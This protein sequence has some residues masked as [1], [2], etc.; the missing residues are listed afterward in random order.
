[1]AASST[2]GIANPNPGLFEE[3]ETAEAQMGFIGYPENIIGSYSES[4]KAG[5]FSLPINSLVHHVDS[6]LSQTL[7]SSASKHITN[8]GG[9][10]HLLSLHT[11]SANLWY[12]SYLFPLSDSI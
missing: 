8:C 11:S 7:I 2:Q 1:M 6:N 4:L 9:Q 5:L 10:S 12:S 3:E